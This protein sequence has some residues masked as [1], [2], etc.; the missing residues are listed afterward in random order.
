M[1]FRG[2]RVCCY[3]E[4]EFSPTRLDSPHSPLPKR[5]SA[6]LQKKYQQVHVF[7]FGL[8]DAAQLPSPLQ[9]HA[10]DLAVQVVQEGLGVLHDQLN[11]YRI[12]ELLDI[13]SY[14]YIMI[15]LYHFF[16]IM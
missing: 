16:S 9:H 11:R 4:L 7:V 8:Q 1:N 14:N 5:W 13:F 6:E 3:N 10:D 15:N 2:C 12:T